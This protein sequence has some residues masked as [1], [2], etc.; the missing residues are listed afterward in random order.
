MG[1]RVHINLADVV[2]NPSAKVEIYSTSLAV[3]NGS[4]DSDIVQ[5]AKVSLEGHDPL[6][7]DVS[8]FEGS[9][10]LS[11]DFNMWSPNFQ[12][13]LEFVTALAPFEVA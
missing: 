13:K 4:D 11:M 8:V 6:V 3:L 1:K 7:F 9:I 12:K 10:H 5:I 2:V